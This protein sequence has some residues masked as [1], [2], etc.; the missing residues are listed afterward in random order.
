MKAKLNKQ[1]HIT[2]KAETVSEGFALKSFFDNGEKCKTCN[3]P[4][5]LITVDYS[6]LDPKKKKSDTVNER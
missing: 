3:F 5:E 2:V 1:G 6:I 4:I